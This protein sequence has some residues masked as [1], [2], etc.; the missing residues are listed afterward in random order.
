MNFVKCLDGLELH[1][2]RVLHQQVRCILI[3]DGAIIPE[4]NTMLLRHGKTALA[5]LVSKRVLLHVLDES[6]SGRIGN[7]HG[8]PDDNLGVSIDTGFICVHLR[9]LRFQF[10]N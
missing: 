6:R 8:A 3:D 4:D 9:Y 2:Q 10:L 7:S 5:K 1:K